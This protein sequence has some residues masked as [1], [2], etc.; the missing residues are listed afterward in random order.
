MSTW[1]KQTLFV[2]RSPTG[3]I[4]G[5]SESVPRGY[6]EPT[7]KELREAY[8]APTEHYKKKVAEKK[9]WMGD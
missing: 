9:R 5:I 1:H 6:K 2:L 3:V 7:V 8:R 4:V